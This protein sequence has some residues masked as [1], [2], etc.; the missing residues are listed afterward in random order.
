MNA[1]F[2]VHKMDPSDIKF[3]SMQRRENAQNLAEAVRWTALQ[4]VQMVMIEV[5][6]MH[7]AGKPTG[8]EKVSE[9]ISPH[10]SLKLWLVQS[11]LTQ[12][13]GRGIWGRYPQR[14]VI[15]EIIWLVSYWVIWESSGRRVS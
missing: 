14:A 9:R 10:F 12:N 7:K 4:K 6:E 2:I 15:W 11:D 13:L 5:R 3:E 1:K 8:P